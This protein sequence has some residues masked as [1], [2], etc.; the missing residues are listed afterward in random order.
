[1]NN[2]Q[3]TLSTI[4]GAV[5]GASIL[6]TLAFAQIFTIFHDTNV[7]PSSVSGAIGTPTMAAKSLGSVSGYCECRCASVSA[8]AERAV[9]DQINNFLNSGFFME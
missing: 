8:P 1:M 5:G 3:P 9:L 2:L 7:A 4:G 6:G